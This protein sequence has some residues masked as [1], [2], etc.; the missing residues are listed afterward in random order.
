MLICSKLSFQ[1]YNSTD[2]VVC[3][4]QMSKFYS[5]GIVRIFHLKI[6]EKYI[7]QQKHIGKDHIVVGDTYSQTI[8]TE[9][10]CR[11]KFITYVEQ[12]LYVS[13]NFNPFCSRYN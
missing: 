4:D 7:Q 2:G 6:H 11:N 12:N 9:I 5:H 10:A 8:T 3:H 13:I 1:K